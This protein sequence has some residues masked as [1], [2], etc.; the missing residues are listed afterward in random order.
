MIPLML[1]LSSRIVR[2]FGGGEVGAR[3][4]AFFA[5]EAVV[6][7]F[8]R[9][10]SSRFSTLPVKSEVLDV[11]LLDD[12]TLGTLIDGAFLVIAATSAPDQ[13]NRIGRIC[14]ESGVLFNNADGEQG[15]VLIPAVV[16]G[17]HYQIAVS[18]GGNSP[19][20]ARFVRETIEKE[21]PCLD[22]MI[23]LQREVRAAL[24]QLPLT[25]DDRRRILSAILRDPLVKSALKNGIDQAN[26]VVQAHYLQA[27][28]PDG[29]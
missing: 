2:I 20:V 16:R 22:R 6:Q 24:K 9:S 21:L 3:K 13:N 25:S 11:A 28:S 23:L 27:G 8:S 12:R 10:F 1:D 4:A 14:R 15:D 29:C 18:T 7:V 26:D 17:E 19:A 5:D